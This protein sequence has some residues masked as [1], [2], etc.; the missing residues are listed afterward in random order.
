MQEWS[1]SSATGSEPG[2]ILKRIPRVHRCGG[3]GGGRLSPKRYGPGERDR[4][5]R[6]F[7]AI[8]DLGNSKVV[9]Y[10]MYDSRE[11]ALEAAGLSE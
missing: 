10:R 4:I 3:F 11:E 6:E 2:G 9:R 8:Y 1:N 5:D 7:F